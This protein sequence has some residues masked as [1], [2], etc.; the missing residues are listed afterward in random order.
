MLNLGPLRRYSS[1]RAG[2]QPWSYHRH[3]SEPVIYPLCWTC[4]YRK[5]AAGDFTAL[6]WWEGEPAFFLCLHGSHLWRYHWGMWKIKENA[7]FSEDSDFSPS[8]AGK[9]NVPTPQRASLMLR[10]TSDWQRQHPAP[11]FPQSPSTWGAWSN[12]PWQVS[13]GRGEDEEKPLSGSR[14][15]QGSG[16]GRGLW[17]KV[18][19][20]GVQS[21]CPMSPGVSRCPLPLGSLS[22]RSDTSPSPGPGMGPD[23]QMVCTMITE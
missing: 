3:C 21:Q 17:W 9:S 6:W 7:L 22:A 20:A 8:N 2:F 5:L 15:G 4:S 12:S 11:L 10:I 1:S 18:G 13:E 23:S 14:W 19:E 16:L